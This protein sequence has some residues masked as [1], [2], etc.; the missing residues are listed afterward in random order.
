[1]FAEGLSGRKGSIGKEYKKVPV[2]EDS[3]RGK[4][5]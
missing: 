3:G 2:Q 1:M 5:G 4:S